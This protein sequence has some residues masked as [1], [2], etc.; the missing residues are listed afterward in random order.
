MKKEA[1][2]KGGSP[3]VHTSPG[4]LMSVFSRKKKS[5]FFQKKMSDWSLTLQ[6]PLR[7]CIQTSDCSFTSNMCLLVLGLPLLPP[8]SVSLAFHSTHMFMCFWQLSFSTASLAIAAAI[9]KPF[10]PFSSSLCSKLL[11]GK[12]DKCLQPVLFEQINH[13]WYA[14]CFHKEKYLGLWWELSKLSPA[15]WSQSSQ[16]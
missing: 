15:E 2:L 8:S 3:C 1:T 16:H 4:F 10:T 11:C 14:E 6:G 9:C 5:H 12:G 7:L 13:C